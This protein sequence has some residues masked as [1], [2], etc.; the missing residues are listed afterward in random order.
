MKLVA[1][2]GGGGKTTIS[3]KYPNLFLDIDNFVWSEKNRV[4]HPKIIECLETKNYELLGSIYKEILVTNKEYLKSQNKIILVHHPDNADWLEGE[5]I[6][7][8]KPC[9]EL[10]LDNISK[11]DNNLRAVSIN[12]WYELKD[13]HIFE[14]HQ[15]LEK[16]VLNLVKN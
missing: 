8:L 2:C 4:F 1:I 6:C 16:I 5:C 12:S 7:K 10:L 14:N 15:E 9:Y 3:E 11:R 13:A